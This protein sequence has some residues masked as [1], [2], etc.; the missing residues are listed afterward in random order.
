[1]VGGATFALLGLIPSAFVGTTAS[2]GESSNPAAIP[3]PALPPA[4]TTASW[5]NRLI[6]ILFA[7]AGRLLAVT[8]YSAVL[9][10]AGS[11]AHS[12]TTTIA[13]LATLTIQSTVALG[14][15]VSGELADRW[16][17]T[18]TAAAATLFLILGIGGFALPPHP[19]AALASGAL[20]GAASGTVQTAALTLMMRR[21]HSPAR[22]EQLSATWNITFD[23]G[24]GA[25]ALPARH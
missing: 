1:M 24:L 12:A 11:L 18:G 5:P 22:S 6:A 16:S 14:P 15:L 7:L 13:V 9:S 19:L 21:A 10:S 20:V 2:T 8:L 4:H 25:G 3:K 23:L 17:A